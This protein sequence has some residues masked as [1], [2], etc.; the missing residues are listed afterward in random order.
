MTGGVPTWSQRQ[1]RLSL[2]MSQQQQQPKSGDCDTTATSSKKLLTNRRAVLAQSSLAFLASIA[3]LSSPLA[4]AQAAAST[5]NAVP[6]DISGQDWS[7][8]DLTGWDFTNVKAVGTKF[9][10][11]KLEGAK[12]TKADLSNA[13]FVA[14]NV[15]A[16]TFTDAKLDGA[17]LDK[18]LAQRAIFSGTILDLGSAVGVDLTDSLWPSKYRIMICDMDDVISGVNP[19]TGIESKESLMCTD[20]LHSSWERY[21]EYIYNTSNNHGV[22]SQRCN[23]KN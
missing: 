22:W 9:D 18:A 15:Q 16:A 14:A 21:Y 17:S 2:D 11:S 20:Y 23:R 6:K 1:Q 7:G 3:T 5:I 8:R 10:R 19:E 13:S 4:P 12:F